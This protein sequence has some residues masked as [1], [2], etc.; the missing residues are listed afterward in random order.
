MAALQSSICPDNN[1][2]IMR[3]REPYF[4]I[5][6]TRGD[7]K[8]VRN[9]SGRAEKRQAPANAASPDMQRSNKKR[10]ST[11]PRTRKRAKIQELF[12]QNT[13]FPGKML[14][15]GGVSS[16]ASLQLQNENWDEDVNISSTSAPSKSPRDRPSTLLTFAASWKLSK[17]EPCFS[18]TR[19]AID[20]GC[21]NRS[22]P[23]PLKPS[24][25]SD[26]TPRSGV[27]KHVHFSFRDEE[28]RYEVTKAKDE[29]KNSWLD[30]DVTEAI[31]LMGNKSNDLILVHGLIS[32]GPSGRSTSSD[33][34]ICKDV[35]EYMV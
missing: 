19:N 6:I 23:L 15:H 22:Q 29:I 1:D 11:G 26:S 3:S 31:E 8:L 30:I 4:F 35:K 25:K 18:M 21:S 20:A 13:I 24:L 5:F 27:A 28:M 7:K 12:L 9:W 10:M 14:L 2:K 16:T 32:F 17:H 33:I 34:D